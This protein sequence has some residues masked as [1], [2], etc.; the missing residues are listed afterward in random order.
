MANATAAVMART[1]ALFDELQP[2]ATMLDDHPRGGA[3]VLAH[4]GPVRVATSKLER[5]VSFTVVDVVN[6][7][8]GPAR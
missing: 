4:R 8:D 3:A 1:R 7:A 5:P 6:S 2:L